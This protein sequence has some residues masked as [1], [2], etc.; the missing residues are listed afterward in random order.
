V[1]LEHDLIAAITAELA[2]IEERERV[3]DHR[4]GHGD[5]LHWVDAGKGNVTLR[6]SSKGQ[7]FRWSGPAAKL[8]E[9]LRQVPS[10]GG[11]EAVRSECCR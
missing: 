11:A 3:H 10:G 7:D 2:R 9:R 5:R 6:G 1:P 8:L 4:L